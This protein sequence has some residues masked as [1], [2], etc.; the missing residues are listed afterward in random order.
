MKQYNCKPCGFVT[1]NKTDF[2]RHLHTKRHAVKCPDD[3]PEKISSTEP[4]QFECI[5]CHTFLETGEKLDKHMDNCPVILRIKLIESEKDKEV[6]K[7]KLENALKELEL[8]NRFHK[9]IVHEKDLVVVEKDNTIG[10][11]KEENKYHKDSL[12]KQVNTVNQITTGAIKYLQ[13]HCPNAPRLEAPKDY[14]AVWEELEE[15]KL[16]LKN[17][18][19]WASN[20]DLALRLSEKLLSIYKKKDATQQ[21]LWGVDSSRNNYAEM[22]EDWII[23][24]EGAKIREKIIIPFIDDLWERVSNEYDNG[25][26][27]YPLVSNLFPNVKFA[28]DG[29]GR[30]KLIKKML[31]HMCGELYLNKDGKKKNGKFLTYVGPKKEEDE[32]V[33]EPV[34]SDKSVQKDKKKPTPKSQKKAIK[35]EPESE[36]YHSTDSSDHPSDSDQC[37]K[38][39]DEI[40]KRY[41]KEKAKKEQKEIVIIDT[42]KKGKRV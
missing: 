41:E 8:S 3:V 1:Y 14:D 17:V 11:I 23:D 39:Y 33:E 13:Q 2:D 6:L 40:C 10:I 31:R 30:E 5:N 4:K 9:D 34:D 21:S 27:K 18:C 42:K 7:V 35:K 20:K 26:N 24:K 15:K 25:G 38:K 36:P 22:E 29:S 37:D 12:D 28:L 19:T 16:L 32:S